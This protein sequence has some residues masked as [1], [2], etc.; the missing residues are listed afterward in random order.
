MEEIRELTSSVTGNLI[1]FEK[2]TDHFNERFGTRFVRFN[3]TFHDYQNLDLQETEDNILEDFRLFFN[4]I[5][6]VYDD[7]ENIMLSCRFIQESLLHGSIGIPFIE[8]ELILRNL[9]K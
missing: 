7:T 6:G 3:L 1:H 5:E 2:L 4:E 8:S 9:T